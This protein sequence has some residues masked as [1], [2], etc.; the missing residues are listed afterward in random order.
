[1][2]SWMWTKIRQLPQI[3]K[4]ILYIPSEWI[5]TIRDPGS[6]RESDIGLLCDS[7]SGETGASTR[8]MIVYTIY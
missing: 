5:A 7:N 6:Q 1:M 3:C 8:N 2:K 4:S